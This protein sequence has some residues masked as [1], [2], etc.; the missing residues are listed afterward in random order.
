MIGKEK[1]FTCAGDEANEDGALWTMPL[2]L[3][4]VFFF[5]DSFYS[6]A[7]FFWSGVSYLSTGFGPLFF[8]FFIC[9]CSLVFLF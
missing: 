5:S 8:F 2:I 9:V 4:L 3:P 6:V 1:K 7:F